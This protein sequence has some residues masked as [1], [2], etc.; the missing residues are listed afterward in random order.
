MREYVICCKLAAGVV[1]CV[2]V[3]RTVFKSGFIVFADD[4]RCELKQ[5]LITK[6]VK[7][8]EYARGEIVL[9]IF[10]ASLLCTNLVGC[11]GK[12]NVNTCRVL[13]KNFARSRTGRKKIA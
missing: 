1:C 13:C 3:L 7:T 6:L 11:A 8:V 9:G 10:F 12:K 5:G 4:R 2:Y